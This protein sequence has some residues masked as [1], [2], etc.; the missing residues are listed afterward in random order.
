MQKGGFRERA[1]VPVFGTVVPIFC[2]L[3]PVCGA[4]VLFFV[5][6]FRF[7]G[8]R[9]HLPKLGIV[10]KV[11]SEKASAIARMRQKCVRNASKMRQKCVKMG[12]VLLGK[13]ERRKCVRNSSKL[14]QKCV[15][16]PRNTFGG[17]HP[18]DDTEK[19]LFWKPPPF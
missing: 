1:L 2:T 9:E 4:V 7:W 16:N 8:S 12:L 14:R 15:K 3:V 18:L 11:F 5:P 6:S 19:P 10:Q 17:E 13:E